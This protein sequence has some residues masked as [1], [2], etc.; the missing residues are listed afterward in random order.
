MVADVDQR[1]IRVEF[2]SENSDIFEGDA[3]GAVRLVRAVEEN[4]RVRDI[5]RNVDVANDDV[6]NMPRFLRVHVLVD[7]GTSH[8]EPVVAVG[9]VDVEFQLGNVASTPRA[10]EIDVCFTSARSRG[11][12]PNAVVWV[13][14]SLCAKSLFRFGVLDQLR[15]WQLRSR[16]E[17]HQFGRRECL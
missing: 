6:L 9:D 7:D 17:R 10:F 13:Y 14:A 15:L 11:N 2:L 16:N 5:A 1:R 3:V 12:R 8:E 4:T